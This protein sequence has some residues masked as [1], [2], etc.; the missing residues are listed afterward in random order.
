MLHPGQC[1][2]NLKQMTVG[3]REPRELKNPAAATLWRQ[4]GRMF[5]VTA[6]GKPNQKS[7]KCTLNPKP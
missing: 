3:K 2:E 7:L 1:I 4:R 5:W 6:M